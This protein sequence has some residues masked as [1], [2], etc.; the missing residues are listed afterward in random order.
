MA[1][2]KDNKNA[3]K[4]TRAAVSA[5]LREI[6]RAAVNKK[7]FFLGQELVRLGLYK[8]V[9]A[10]WK[11]KFSEYDSILDQMLL[12][13]EQFETNLYLAAL[14]SQ[15]STKLTILCLRNAHKWR[16][17]TEVENPLRPAPAQSNDHS[18]YVSRAA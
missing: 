9:W 6:K 11:R 2:P 13:E 12:I 10:Y 8:D 18:M 4:W 7:R 16:S 15:I 1:A 5:Y 14:S 17:N 3:Q